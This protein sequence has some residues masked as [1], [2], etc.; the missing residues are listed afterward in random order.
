MADVF[1]RILLCA[2]FGA[3]LAG[4]WRSAGLVADGGETDS[5]TQGG[6][7]DPDTGGPWVYEWTSMGSPADGDLSGVYGSSSSDVFAVGADGSLLR[8]D[9]EAWNGMQYPAATPVSDLAGA[10]GTS[11]WDVFAVGSD[12]VIL[13]YDGDDW[14]HM[15]SGTGVN[16]HAVCGRSHD[17][18]YAV[19]DGGALLAYD[20]A[21]WSPIA[22]GTDRNLFAAWCAPGTAVWAAGHANDAFASSVLLRYDGVVTEIDHP[23]ADFMYALGGTGA[24]TVFIG[25]AYD[26]LGDD[27]HT[28]IYRSAGEAAFEPVCSDASLLLDLF[29]VGGGDLWAVGQ[30]A[31]GPSAG[32]ASITRAVDGQLCE[33]ILFDETD[34]LRG[35]WRDPADPMGIVFAVGDGG[36][37]FHGVPTQAY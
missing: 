25:G 15:D 21:T 27:L 13:H 37:I 29:A 8:F 18:V 4:C 3:V 14:T 9:G 23:V 2:I 26:A 33:S 24:D 16:L 35:V 7:T 17:D 5:D 19:G 1:K 6:I 10:W 31:S 30:A 32:F 11:P 36:T 28:E 12:G 22:T 34:M 20:G